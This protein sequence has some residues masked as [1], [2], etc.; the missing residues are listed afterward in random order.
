MAE[1][2]NLRRIV[3]ELRAERDWLTQAIAGLQRLEAARKRTSCEEVEQLLQHLA[4]QRA[5]THAAK[6]VPF[7]TKTYQSGR[8]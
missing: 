2:M 1:T 3:R 7:P 8:R 5:V 4:S 6:V